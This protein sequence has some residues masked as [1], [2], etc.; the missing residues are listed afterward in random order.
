[1]K[2]LQVPVIRLMFSLFFSFRSGFFYNLWFTRF[3]PISPL[4]FFGL[5]FLQKKIQVCKIIYKSAQLVTVLS[6]NNF[7]YIISFLSFSW[8]FYSSVLSEQFFDILGYSWDSFFSFTRI[9]WYFFDFSF[10][11]ETDTIIKHNFQF[12][13]TGYCT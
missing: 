5:L 11:L 2:F 10:S 9:L 3:F 8:F 6:S 1:M 4:I 12:W 7:T 13:T